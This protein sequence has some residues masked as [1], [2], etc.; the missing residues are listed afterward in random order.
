MEGPFPQFLLSKGAGLEE[1]HLKLDAS[2]LRAFYFTAAERQLAGKRP[3][4]LP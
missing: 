4:G 3:H 2:Q 1:Q